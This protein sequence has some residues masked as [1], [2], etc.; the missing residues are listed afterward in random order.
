MAREVCPASSA[1]L[2]QGYSNFDAESI[3]FRY[4]LAGQALKKP[5]EHTSCDRKWTM[6]NQQDAKNAENL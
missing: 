6:L 5:I 3:V 2:S 1:H 4:F